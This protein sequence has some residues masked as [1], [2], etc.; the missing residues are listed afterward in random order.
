[1]R[2][3]QYLPPSERELRPVMARLNSADL[4]TLDTLIAAGIATSR[5]EAVRWCI[6]RTRERTTY[7]Q[8]QQTVLELKQLATQF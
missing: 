1:M 6:A 7:P 8:L 2:A 3:D 5:A 4:E